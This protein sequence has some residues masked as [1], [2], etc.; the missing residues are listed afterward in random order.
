MLPHRPSLVGRPA[1]AGAHDQVTGPGDGHPLPAAISRA[2]DG[3]GI[4][5]ALSTT[6]TIEPQSADIPITVVYRISRQSVTRGKYPRYRRTLD[7][8]M[9]CQYSVGCSR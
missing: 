3:P 2:T 1:A 9:R 4:T 7:Q 6:Y 8:V 5:R